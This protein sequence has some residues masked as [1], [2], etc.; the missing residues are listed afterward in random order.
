MTTV[1]GCDLPEDV[2]YNLEK[3]TWARL[4]DDGTVRL[5]MT[6]VAGK[7]AGGSL[8]AVTV[9]A[10]KVGKEIAAGKSVATVESSKY[11][12]P[13]PAPVSGTLL[14]GNDQLSTEPNLATTD[15]YGEGW[16]AELTPS[17]WEGE[18]AELATGP[19]GV[20]AY[21]AWLEAEGVSCG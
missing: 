18:S 10:R 7:L 15:P 4:L 9:S 19:D 5:G 21:Q 3:H 6:S 17:D 1:N 2:F 12:G 13:V 8:A 11:V 16:I 20:A 14:R